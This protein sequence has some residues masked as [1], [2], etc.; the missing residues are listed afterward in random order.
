MEKKVLKKY[1]TDD[2]LKTE[3]TKDMKYTVHADILKN[4]DIIRLVFHDSKTGVP[5]FCIFSSHEDFITWDYK[6]SKWSSAMIEKWQL[7]NYTW[8]SGKWNCQHIFQYDS[9]SSMTCGKTF[10]GLNED[11]VKCMDTFQKSVRKKQLDKKHD[12]ERMKIDTIMSQAR[13][14][15]KTFMHW[16]D[17][18]P[19]QKSRYIYYKRHGKKICGYCTVCG[20]DVMLGDARHNKPGVC[21]HCHTHITFKAVGLS[22]NVIDNARVEYV[23]R[24]NKDQLM[25]RLFN[26]G[27]KYGENYREAKYSIDEKSRYIIE[28]DGKSQNYVRN[29]N[30]DWLGKWKRM[31][32]MYF[33][34]YIYTP[35]MTSVLH[36]TAWQYCAIQQYARHTP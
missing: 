15:P 14:L 2:I 22:K 20:S 19:L 31:Q 10:Y 1:I 24:V 36:G 35:N 23:Q 16:L 30:V 34:A 27:K 26:I 17:R 21:P 4:A 28:P 18:M 6:K 9:I 32:T 12:K 13:P 3:R 29:T 25:V 33:Y 7:F 11:T 8:K 5:V